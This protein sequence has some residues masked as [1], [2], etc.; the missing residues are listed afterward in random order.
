MMQ[1]EKSRGRSR[2]RLLSLALAVVVAL[3]VVNIPAVASGIRSL[4]TAAFKFIETQKG[5]SDNLIDVF[6]SKPVQDIDEESDGADAPIELTVNAYKAVKEDSSANEVKEEEKDLLDPEIAAE[7]PGGTEKLMQY[8]SLN[9]R[10][11]F[12][13]F[14][15]NRTGKS[16]IGFIIQPDGSISDVKTLESSWP[17]LD[18]EAM[19]VV[20]AMPKWTPAT[21]DGKPVASQFSIPINFR[22]QDSG[23][24]KAT[25]PNEEASFIQLSKNGGAKL[26]VGPHDKDCEVADIQAIR[27]DGKLLTGDM[28]IDLSDIETS[29]T[30]PPSEEFPGGLWD[31]KLKKK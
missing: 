19:R 14:T 11:P 9:I 28:T 29:E 6:Q 26:M 22:L 8:L 20:K 2:L 16:V 12:S 18:E 5:M 31:I 4:E 13:A 3:A 17:D 21:T 7:F 24:T 10:Y 15:D 1:K 23:E 27:V 30:F 25:T